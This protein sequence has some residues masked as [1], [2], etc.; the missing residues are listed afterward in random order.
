MSNPNSHALMNAAWAKVLQAVSEN[1]ADPAEVAKYLDL[2][3]EEGPPGARTVTRMAEYAEQVAQDLK[4]LAIRLR[5]GLPPC[6]KREVGILT[7]S[8][9]D[10]QLSRRGR[11][12]MGRLGIQ[13]IG[14]LVRRRPEELLEVKNFGLKALNEV[15]EH[16]AK[17]ELKLRGD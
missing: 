10:L 12:A 9:E 5:Q 11:K 2:L 7:K 13:T 1:R 8:V 17:H 3:I 6:I 14:D 15:R 16:L 4:S